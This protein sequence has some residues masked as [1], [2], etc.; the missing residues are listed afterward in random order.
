MPNYNQALENF[1][2]VRTLQFTAAFLLFLTLIETINAIIGPHFVAQEHKLVLVPVLQLV[3]INIG[4]G[5]FR[6]MLLLAL[7]E[8]IKLL[9]NKDAQ[10]K[11]KT[12]SKNSKSK[13][14]K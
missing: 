14:A 3:I 9:R 1:P 11:S 8:L 2:I 13:A 12:S 6:A 10:S 4:E 5:L 7:A